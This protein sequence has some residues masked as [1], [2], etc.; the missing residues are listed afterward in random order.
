MATH[1]WERMIAMLDKKLWIIK[2]VALLALLAGASGAVQP[3]NGMLVASAQGPVGDPERYGVECTSPS[4]DEMSADSDEATP[5]TLSGLPES[6]SHLRASRVTSTTLTLSWRDNSDNE[7]GFTI[8][9]WVN[10]GWW[11]RIAQVGANVTMCRSTDLTPHTIYAYRVQAFN[12]DGVS[13][14]SQAVT[15]AT[16]EY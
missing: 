6:P 10:G 1:G 16:K 4:A 12:A 9:R 15:V 7:Q 3:R 8:E 14:F 13:E 2:I 5:V 11:T